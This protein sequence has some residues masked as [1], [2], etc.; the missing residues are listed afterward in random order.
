MRFTSALLCCVLCVGV[1]FAGG[2]STVR[3][4]S[5][6]TRA[7]VGA[8]ADAPPAAAALPGSGDEARSYEQRET[9][10]PAVQDFKGGDVTIGVS[11]FVLVLVIVI[12]VLLSR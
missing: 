1:L 12:I 8:S 7:A 5:G 3:A 6:E 11:V 10:S 9:E 4:D 2:V